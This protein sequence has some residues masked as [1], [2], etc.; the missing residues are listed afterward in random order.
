[1]P[2]QAF[3]PLFRV[4]PC[5]T[6]DRNC[7]IPRTLRVSLESL[8]LKIRSFPTQLFCGLA[9]T[10]ASL[11]LGA[12]HAPLYYHP[13]FNFAGRPTPP[14][15]LL[16]RVMVSYT[17]NGGTGGAEI[18]DALNDLRRNIQNTIPAWFINA[19][20]GSQPTTIISFPEQTTGYILSYTDGNFSTINYSKE[21][22]SGS[23]A[24]SFGPTPSSVAASTLGAHILSEPMRTPVRSSS[25]AMVRN[26][27][28]ACPMS[29]RL[30]PIKARPSSWQWCAIRIRYIAL[31]SCRQP[32]PP[33]CP[34]AMSIA[35]HAAAA[36]ARLP[37]LL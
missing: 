8:P 14:S 28:S 3:G 26:M 19:F 9:L 23:A 35:S 18:L 7:S 13:E 24:F 27:P 25:P 2:Q 30:S 33:F 29:I 12:C 37:G 21:A 34:P 6:C 10:A 1:M 15:G 32:A 36:H 20:S 17:A 5:Y 22:A 16:N 11:V 31:S 4:L